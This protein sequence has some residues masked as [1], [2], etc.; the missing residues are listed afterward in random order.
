[1]A[2][3]VNRYFISD[4]N[5]PRAHRAADA[6][7]VF[8]G[9]VLVLWT[10]FTADR[11]LAI[12]EA[13]VALTAS[14][15]TWF[16]QVYEIVY[17]LG[18]LYV[19]VLFVAVLVQGRR[20]LDLLR[21]MTLAL[22]ASFG[23]ALLLVW[24]VDGTF[25]VVLPEFNTAEPEPA[26]PILRVAMVTSVIA[27][28]AP[29]LARP[30]R[31]FGW[32]IVLVVAISGFSLGFGF[33]GD[34]LGGVG[35]GIAAAGT[36][37]LIFGSPSGYPNIAAIAA[38]LADLG[39][40]AHD[41]AV[42]PDQSWGV[43]RLSGVLDD[44]GRFEVKAYGRDATDS[45]WLSKAWR[46]IWYREE[47]QQFTFS[48]LQGVEHEALATVVAQQSGVEVPSLLAV[49]I[50]GD[51]VAL[52]ALSRRGE[53]L[54]G[55]PLS[56]A[57]LVAA[58]HQVGLLHDAGIT[59]G[60]LTLDAI[61]I[62]GDQPALRELNAASFN[63]S[64]ARLSLDVVSLLYE[65][66]VEVGAKDAVAAAGQELG[67]DRLIGA[68]PYLQ[69]PALTKEQR[70]AAD[71]PKTVIKE[72]R[73]A[74]A[75]AADIELPEP[76]KLRRIRWQDLVM[77][78]LSL[79]AFYA[80]I[81]LLSDID[82]AAVWEVVQDANWA[83][84]MIGFLIGQ[85]VFLPEATGM[86]F[87]TG[88]PLP[89]RPLTTLQ[90]SVKWIGLAIPSAAGRIT[91]NTL[92]LRKYG[93]P[94]TIAL[95]QGA[96][97][98]VSGFFVEAAIL[99]IAFI[100]A[101]INLDL[102]TDEVRW[103]LILA[104]VV[105]LIVASVVAVWRVKRLRDVVIPVLTD[106]WHLLWG[107]MKDPGRALGLLGSNLGSRLILAVTLW[108][109]LQAIGEPLPL[110]TCLVVTVATNLLA[111]LVPIPGGIGVA[112]AVLTSFLVLA[113]LG[114]DEAF[115]AAVVFR[116]ATFYIPAGEGFFALKWLQ[117]GGYL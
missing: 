66:A 31:R 30:I 20:R 6:V 59:H 34:A 47:G 29:Q 21:D 19:V 14:F 25:P 53:P 61:T 88:Y 75:G 98:G 69:M 72:L 110:V 26:F 85:F 40:A 60:G 56:R 86:M 74:I 90:V 37:L 16:D 114:T 24:L 18:A 64:E 63:P 67:D 27:V 107:V 11:V 91:M 105:L 117:D 113:G 58:W 46:S 101:D 55:K 7:A 84:I 106:A 2:P 32:L 76:A 93:V 17:S 102:D 41:L 10:G 22:V 39:L 54:Q 4:P 87:A 38:G 12:E 80:L 36:I 1:M 104:I 48:R 108:F 95:T 81:G 96:I 111:G 92:F 109:I 77:P 51:D 49:G 100:A 33:P 15:P 23:I 8:V 57:T 79:V 35:L 28:A 3:T 62:D 13:L 116:V 78:A 89:L 50:G 52:L 70:K 42:T 45:Q 71:R 65:T 94:P 44:G 82:F 115:A 83:W 9:V 73:E 112:E 43:R 68:L 97:D 99:L 5:Q 103:G